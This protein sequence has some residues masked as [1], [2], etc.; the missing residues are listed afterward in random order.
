MAEHRIRGRAQT[1]A[2]KCDVSQRIL[3]AW[4]RVSSLRLGQFI[5]NA[6]RHHRDHSAGPD[7]FSIEDEALAAACERYSLAVSK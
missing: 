3:A 2:E 5:N 1:Y 4:T 6:E 7:L